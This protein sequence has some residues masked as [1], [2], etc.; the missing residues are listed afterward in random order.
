MMEGVHSGERH[1]G[2]QGKFGKYKGTGWRVWE[3]VQGKDWRSK[4]IGR[5]RQ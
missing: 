1:L 5:R 3:E 4:M 2:K